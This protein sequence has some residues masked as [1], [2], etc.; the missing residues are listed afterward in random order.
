MPEWLK[1]PDCKS[2][3]TAYAGSN[4]APPIP[5]RSQLDV[6]EAPGAGQRTSGEPSAANGYPTAPHRPDAGPAGLAGR[7]DRGCNSMVE[8]LPSKQVV[9]VRF[10]SPALHDPREADP[11]HN[12]PRR[13]R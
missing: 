9:W 4:P 1:G 13:P 6:S 7:T 5:V 11:N 12:H 8:Y 2:G 3:G 10:P